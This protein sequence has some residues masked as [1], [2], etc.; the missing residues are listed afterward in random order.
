MADAV[1]TA[2]RPW[3]D[4]PLALF[5]QS[6]GAC[7]AYEVAL[8]LETRGIVPCSTASAPGRT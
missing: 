1:T 2:L 5:G 7:V 6:M 8:R 3:F 4:R